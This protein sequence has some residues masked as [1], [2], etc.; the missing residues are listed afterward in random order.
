ESMLHVTAS[1]WA[2]FGSGFGVV[3]R[4]QDGADYCQYDASYY[5]G[6]T[7][8]ARGTGTPARVG[9]TSPDVIPVEEGGNCEP[10]E[11]CYDNHGIEL[12]LTEDWRQYK[13]K[14]ESLV[15]EGWGVAA[16]PLKSTELF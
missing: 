15:Q 4:W 9:F 10:R 2:D 3:M 13:F 12:V 5:D 8:W 7:F 1:G 16:G 14:F 6:I 11:S